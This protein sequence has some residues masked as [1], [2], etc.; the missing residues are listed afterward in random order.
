MNVPLGVR[1]LHYLGKVEK[2][3]LKFVSNPVAFNFA[4]KSKGIF[5]LVSIFY[6]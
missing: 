1:L 3:F 6:Q 4:K 2:N 5:F